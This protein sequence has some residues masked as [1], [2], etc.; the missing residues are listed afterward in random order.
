MSRPCSCIRSCVIFSA[1]VMLI[2]QPARAQVAQPSGGATQ[3]SLIPRPPVENSIPARVDPRVELLSIVFRLIEAYEYNQP[4]STSIYSRAVSAHFGK[5]IRHPAI[6]LA[7][8]LRDERSI[9]FDAV[10]SFAAH[11]KDLDSC[12][13]AMPLD[14]W[15]ATFDA[16]WDTGSATAFAEALKR[17]VRDAEFQKFWEEQKP[18]R[19]AAEGRMRVALERRPLKQ[20]IESFFGV[21]LQPESRVCIGLLNGGANYGSSVLY[22]DGRL[23]VF[24][25]I[26]VWHWDAQGL[27]VFNDS[28]RDTI[29][30]EFCHPLVNPLVDRHLAKLLPAGEKLLNLQRKA[31]SSQ[32]Y[33]EP[34][35]VL[36]E[37]LVRASVVHILSAGDGEQAGAAQL[38]TEI[39]RGFWWSP[40]LGESLARFSKDRERYPTL[41]SFMDEIA[42][43]LARAAQQPDSLLSRVPKLVTL[44]PKAGAEK[45]AREVQFRLEFDRPMD[46]ASRGLSFEKDGAFEAVKPGKFDAGGRVYT[47]TLRFKPGAVVQAWVNRTGQ[48]FMTDQGYATE[49]RTFEFKVE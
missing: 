31:M 17:F 2:G 33:G 4:S 7:A 34:R 24:P 32:A 39:S 18:F 23:V 42:A 13:F 16:R 25:T 8:K 27:P 21:S 28:D 44:D 47:T 45:L 29:V 19:E 22:P 40:L 15:P 1:W 48:G 26:G 43:D 35:T 30:H 5:H 9:G 14:P 12:S 6:L 10:A 38:K 20:W 11:L 49:S 41:A 3:Q 37:S 46:P 36:Y